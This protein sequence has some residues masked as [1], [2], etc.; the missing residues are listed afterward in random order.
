MYLKRLSFTNFKNIEQV[1]LECSPVLNCFVGN[2]GE[3]K[4]NLLD[5]IHYLSMCKSHFRA[6]DSDNIRNFQNFFLLKGVYELRDEEITISCGARRFGLKNFKRNGKEYTRLSE[7]IGLLPLIMITPSDSSL[8]T[9]SGEER[10]RFLNS[11]LSQKNKP[12]LEDILKYNHL[13]THRNK[14]LKTGNIDGEL[15]KVLDAQL[16]VTGQTIYRKRK[17]LIQ[18][19]QSDFRDVYA[20]IS[21]SQERPNL[22][23]RSELNQGMFTDLLAMSYNRDLHMQHTTVGVHRDDL[24]MET[25]GRSVRYSGSQGQQKTFLIAMKL[26]QFHAIKQHFGFAPILLLDDIFDKLDTGRVLRLISLVVS[27][28]FGQIF[29]TDSNK[30]RLQQVLAKTEADHKLFRIHNGKAILL[31]ESTTSRPAPS[32]TPSET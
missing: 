28:D 7:H 25:D 29:I 20:A 3:G 10:R 13:I 12:Y 26:A 8:I 9:D 21:N 4:T 5:G 31:S 30:Q 16:A 1:D 22:R 11:V 23:Y 32:T 14:L 2:N 27:G 6:S 24:L 15:L 18:S 19:I 17:V